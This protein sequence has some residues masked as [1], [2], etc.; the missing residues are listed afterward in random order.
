[1]IRK[2][3]NR[4]SEKIMLHQNT[5]ARSE[6]HTSELQ[7]RPHIV[8]RLLLEKTAPHTPAPCPDKFAR[9][10]RRPRARCLPPRSNETG[11]GPSAA[12]FMMAVPVAVS[13][14]NFFKDTAP[15]DI[16][17]LPLPAPLPL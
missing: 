5:R 17:T 3:G 10:S 7:S 12:D 16:Y 2:S 9:Y 1:M 4:F 11:R 15:C 6:E 13:P 14:L 8:C